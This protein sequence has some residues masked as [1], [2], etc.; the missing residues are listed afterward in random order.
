MQG[1]ALHSLLRQIASAIRTAAACATPEWAQSLLVAPVFDKSEI[2]KP[3]DIAS[4]AYRVTVPGELVRL[5]FY[6][7]DLAAV[8][9][10]YRRFIRAEIE[11]FIIGVGNVVAEDTAEG[12]IVFSR[13]KRDSASHDITPAMIAAGSAALEAFPA[14]DLW[15][16]WISSSDVVQA[17]YSAMRS[18]S[19]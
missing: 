1:E 18:S 17:V 15:E 14:I 16:G 8:T 19:E 5:D 9:L 10:D 13:E 6:P 11:P 7:N 4:C 3:L 12:I 2:P